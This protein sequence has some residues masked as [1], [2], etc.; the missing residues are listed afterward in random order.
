VNGA[1]Q[2]PNSLYHCAYKLQQSIILLYFYSQCSIAVHRSARWKLY[3]YIC[4]L[5]WHGSYFGTFVHM[6]DIEVISLRLCIC[7]TRK[8]FRYVCA[9]AWHGNYFVTFVHMHDKEDIS[10]RLC[11]CITWK[12]FHYVCA[13]ALHG[14]YF[15]TFLRMHD[16]EVILLRLC[17]CI[18][19]KLY[20][21]VCAYA[22][23][24]NYFVTFVHMHDVQWSVLRVPLSKRFSVGSF[25]EPVFS[26]SQ[27]RSHFRNVN[28]NIPPFI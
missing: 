6:H 17:I 23:Q 3:R 2:F 22:W 25:P 7:M 16:K 12:L 26:T 10:L 21:Y 13:Y 5:A 28:F 4:A 27:S 19:W 11:I 24:G 20:R 9:Y 14:N 15:V 8:I 18:A 1:S